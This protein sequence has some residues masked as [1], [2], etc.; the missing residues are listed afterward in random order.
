MFL[1]SAF[2]CKQTPFE[3]EI[4]V[5]YFSY[6]NIYIYLIDYTGNVWTQISLSNQWNRNETEN[7]W[8]PQ[9]PKWSQSVCPQS[10]WIAWQTYIAGLIF[11]VPWK[12]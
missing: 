11:K 2:S 8:S 10:S 7:T 6:A 9:Q 4:K 12:H 1:E 5:T 3:L